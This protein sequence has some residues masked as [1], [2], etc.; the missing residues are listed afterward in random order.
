MFF[1]LNSF[2]MSRFVLVLFNAS[3]RF[4]TVALL[5]SIFFVEPAA[6]ASRSVFPR[7][8]PPVYP[9]T[10]PFGDKCRRRRFSPSLFLVLGGNFYQK[11]FPFTFFFQFT[12]SPAA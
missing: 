8:F 7:S 10:P 4:F 5:L 6:C 11:F 3:L 2:K 12:L 1:F 9:T